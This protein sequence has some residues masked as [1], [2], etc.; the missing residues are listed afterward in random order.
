MAHMPKVSVVIP[1]YNRHQFLGGAIASVL[2]QTFQ[3][4]EVI[5]VDDA[6]KDET[7]VMVSSL[8]D[9]RVKYVRHPANRGGSAARNTG[10][11]RSDS[12]YIALL[13]DDDEWLPHKLK[14]QI[15][16]LDNTHPQVGIVY[17]GY[18]IVDRTT[19]AVLG[20]IVPRRR[21]DLSK[22]LLA[23]N[24]LGGASSVLLRRECFDQVGLFDENLPSYQDYDMW[25]RISRVFHFEYIKDPLFRYYV[26][27][28][29]IWMTPRAIN[30]GSEMLLKKYG[31]SS[32]LKRY[33]SYHFLDTGILYCY[34]GEL[35][36]GR[37]AFLRAIRLHPLEMRHYFYF[38][39]SLLGLNIFKKVKENK[40]KMFAILR[41][42]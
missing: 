3:D 6:S 4:F 5:V 17:S 12:S 27:G 8:S 9:K 10:I 32:P 18:H 37:A 23:E 35:R 29:K 36:N 31:A 21:G 33:C 1:T 7:P 13:D 24:H 11:L 26:H 41:S 15:D 39:L 38:C 16:L 25:I 42:N 28:S 30:H 34:R 14:M 2:S 40:E 19:G 20:Q 22:A